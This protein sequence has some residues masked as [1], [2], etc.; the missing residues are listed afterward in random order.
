[1]YATVICVDQKQQSRDQALIRQATLLHPR[2][3]RE[4]L[5]QVHA[6]TFR[7]TPFRQHQIDFSV[8]TRT[9]S[10]TSASHVPTAGGYLRK[11]WLPV[12]GPI[13]RSARSGSAKVSC[14]PGAM[15]DKSR[16]SNFSQPL[17]LSF[18][19]SKTRMDFPTCS[20]TLML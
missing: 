4:N 12:A 18:L 3:I 16:Y 15:H 20:K 2:K 9:I 8:G 1:M 13:S 5:Y 17:S 10:P 19:A 11:S 14:A 7:F 6:S